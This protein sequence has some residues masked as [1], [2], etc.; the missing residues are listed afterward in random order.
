KAP[1]RPLPGRRYPSPTSCRCRGASARG[2][3]SASSA[4]L[5]RRGTAPCFRVMPVLEIAVEPI[6][7]GVHMSDAVGRALKILDDS[8][9][10]YEL[11]QMGTVVRGDIEQLF[12][13]ARRMH[14]AA[15]HGSP[16]VLTTIRID[17]R[18]DDV[19]LRR[20]RGESVHDAA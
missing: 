3:R 19:M 17:D 20:E 10:E 9:V 4:T 8:K 7:D 5:Y 6:G 14:E 18:T 1:R 2:N 12:D 15:R 13:L 11:T 16:R